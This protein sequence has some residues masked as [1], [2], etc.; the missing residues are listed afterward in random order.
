MT[1]TCGRD[2]SL[3]ARTRLRLWA[4]RLALNE[5]NARDAHKLLPLLISLSATQY[6]MIGTVPSPTPAQLDPAPW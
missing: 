2:S 3:L 6:A 4:Q 1:L 5:G